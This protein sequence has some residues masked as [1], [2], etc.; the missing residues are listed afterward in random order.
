MCSCCY[1][2]GC[3]REEGAAKDGV[4][5]G[6]ARGWIVERPQWDTEAENKEQ[7]P[8]Q[9]AWRAQG[10]HGNGDC[11]TKRK[12]LILRLNIAFLCHVSFRFSRWESDRFSSALS[13]VLS[14][15]VASPS[16]CSLSFWEPWLEFVHRLFSRQPTSEGNRSVLVLLLLYFTRRGCHEVW[17]PTSGRVSSCC[18]MGLVGEDFTFDGSVVFRVCA[19][20]LYPLASWLFP[21]LGSQTMP[22]PHTGVCVPQ[23]RDLPVLTPPMGGGSGGPGG[24]R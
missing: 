3:S 20:L 5:D 24:W 2:G 13:P 18:V 15:S 19:S 10:S 16:D 6:R 22:Q 8:D 23:W 14:A 1:V 7:F 4:S 12:P 9:A 21:V 17:S 11:R